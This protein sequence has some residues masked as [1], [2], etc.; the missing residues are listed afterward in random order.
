MHCTLSSGP[1]SF[2][3]DV[4]ALKQNPKVLP[5]RIRSQGERVRELLMTGTEELQSTF[6][7]IL[8][9]KRKMQRKTERNEKKSQT[10]ERESERKVKEKFRKGMKSVLRI[11]QTPALGDAAQLLEQ[12]VDQE[13]VR[14]KVGAEMELQRLHYEL[15]LRNFK[16]FL[17]HTII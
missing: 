10:R 7:Q 13:R 14:A 6:Q 3:E 4:E 2:C 15:L 5:A 8:A 16:L 9:K 17:L 12:A 1:G 11:L